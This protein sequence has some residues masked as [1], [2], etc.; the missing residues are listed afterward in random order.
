MIYTR[1][2]VPLDGSERALAACGPARRLARLHGATLGLVTVAGPDMT[3][4]EI[5]AIVEAGR[6]AAGDSTTQAVVLRGADPAS[7]LARYD[8]EH[9]DTLLCLTTRARRPLGRALLGS[10]ASEVVRGSDQVVVLVGPRCEGADHGD[11]TRLI[12]C[13]DGTPEGE[14]ILSWATRWSAAVGVPL[15]L[16]WVVYP[17]VTPT[18]RIPPTD[19]QIDELGYLRRIALQL[20]GDGHEV[21][22]MTVQHSSSAD[23]LMD[24]AADIPDA[25]LAVSTAGGLADGVDGSTAAEVVRGSSV[26]VLVARHV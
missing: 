21:A 10:V 9:P 20:R 25:L 17:L 15:L 18:A 4:G 22:D 8:R 14:V 3:A 16:V 12:V 24:L 5:D 26:P 11:I 19:A 2:L 1:I 7:T 23:V 6:L 13:L